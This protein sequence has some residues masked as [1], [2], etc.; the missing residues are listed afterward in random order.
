MTEVARPHPLDLI[1]ED[2]VKN[3]HIEEA[4][5][6]TREAI[7]QELRR[8]AYLCGHEVSGRLYSSYLFSDT[9]IET[10]EIMIKT[11]K[12]EFPVR[13]VQLKKP[14]APYTEGQTPTGF[15]TIMV[16]DGY[17]IVAG[18]TNLYRVDGENK[19]TDWNGKPATTEQDAMILNDLIPVLKEEFVKQ[20]QTRGQSD[21]PA[22]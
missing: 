9:H 11:G 2:F 5:E 14:L 6:K 16:E 7:S 21:L 4:R 18:E 17:A 8:I 12:N 20:I 13:I 10:D 19:T 22:N 3:K 1:Y 15:Q